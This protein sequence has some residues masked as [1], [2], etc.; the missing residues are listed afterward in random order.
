MSYLVSP[1]NALNDINRELNR[2]FD[3]RPM[4]A[5]RADVTRWA[6]QV[7]IIETDEGFRVIADVPGVKPEDIEI[8]L[9]KGVLTVKGERSTLTED[10]NE[11]FTRRERIRGSFVRQFNLPESADEETVSA[12]S[13]NGVLE[14]SIPKSTIPSP[15]SIKVEGE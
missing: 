5:Q 10:S 13:V 3:D 2:I 7:D 12:K 4:P 11:S 14:I 9:H 15:I 8:S 1:F 6:P